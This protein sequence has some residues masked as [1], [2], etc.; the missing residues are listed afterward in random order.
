MAS[1]K[2]VIEEESVRGEAPGEAPREEKRKT[3]RRDA[4]NAKD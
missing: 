2:K 4:K 1:R 3:Q